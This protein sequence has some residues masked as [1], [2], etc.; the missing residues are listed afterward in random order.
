MFVLVMVVSRSSG[1]GRRLDGGHAQVDCLAGLSDHRDGLGDLFLV[2]G[3]EVVEVGFDSADQGAQLADLLV[4]GA[5]LGAGPVLN[6]GRGLQTFAVGEQL[7]QVR[8]DPVDGLADA[9]CGGQI[10]M[11]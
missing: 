8:A 11:P 9:L 10:L 4:A 6:V 5:E 1:V 2:L 3:G 7:L